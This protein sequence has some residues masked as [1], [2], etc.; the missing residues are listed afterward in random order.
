M[1]AEK[2]AYRVVRRELGQPGGA[3][4][5]D[6]HAQGSSS[7]VRHCSRRVTMR[8]MRLQ[9][10]RA[11][12]TAG[13]RG[14]AVIAVPFNPDE[15]WGA[16]AEHPVGGTIDGRRVRGTVSPS[17]RC[18]A[19]PVMRRGLREGEVAMGD[20]VTVELAPEGPQRDDLA[21]DIAT[22]LAAN[23]AA[24]AFFDTLAQF[25]RKAYLRW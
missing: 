15:T 14:R 21:D 23:S 8:A 16:K 22:A 1:P 7:D 13:P 17:V 4:D 10:C 19:V 11:V 24:G 5:R 12:I 20:E 2:V 6:D 3:V 25:Y 18:W 9:R